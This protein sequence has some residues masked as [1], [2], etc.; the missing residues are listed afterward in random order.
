MSARTLERPDATLTYWVEGP[1]H[2]QHA[3][4]VLLLHGATLDHHAWQPQ[5]RDLRERYRVVT[6]DLRHHGESTASGTF[7]FHDA[8]DDVL[9]LLDV[10]RPGSLALVGLSLGGN[11]AQE[12]VRR[13]PDRVDA[14][15]VADATSNSAARLPAQR[16]A[17]LA[18]VRP[19]A[20]YP[21]WL[22]LRAAE[23]VTAREP[24]AR[25][26]VRETTAAMPQST[27]VGVLTSLLSDALSVEPEYRLPVPTLI[28]HGADDR[29]GDI[30]VGA[31]RWVRRDPRTELVVIPSAS[32][33][34]NLDA[35]QAFTDALHDFLDRVLPPEVDRI[36]E[37]AGPL[38]R[39]HRSARA[40]W[41]ARRRALAGVV[42]RWRRSARAG[43]AGRHS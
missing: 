18:A 2:A 34:S 17:A 38:R 7:R 32:H 1:Q 31:R 13:V 4:T 28:V 10:L 12:V 11:I 35:P 41:A 37:A 29:V 24:E 23:R 33:L 20:W 16:I 8:V 6:T 5:V 19:L 15:V 25:H 26:Y 36:D 14:L 27:A 3:P 9:A 30:A 39:L 43:R 22:F 42:R 21:R 40:W